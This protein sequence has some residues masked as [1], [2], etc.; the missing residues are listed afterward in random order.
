MDRKELCAETERVA[1]HAMR[2]PRDFDRL[3]EAIFARTREMVSASTL[4][5]LWGYLDSEVEPRRYTLDALSRFVGYADYEA[6]LRRTGEAESDLVLSRRLTAEELREGQL[7]RLTWQPDRVCVV[8]HRGEGRFRVVKAEH[9]KL[10][11][12]DTFTCHLF[13]AHEPLFLDHVVHLGGAPTAYVAGRENG[14]LFETVEE[15]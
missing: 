3:S 14:V 11:V 7:L 9:T 13:I 15:A 4:K 10:S 5:R 2:T 6:F 1:G 8:E 12:G